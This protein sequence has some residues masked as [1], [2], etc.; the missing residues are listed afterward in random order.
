LLILDYEF[1][2]FYF[3]FFCIL[4]F[5]QKFTFFTTQSKK[6]QVFSLTAI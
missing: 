6:T 5:P 3:Y 2:Y 1:F 4:Y